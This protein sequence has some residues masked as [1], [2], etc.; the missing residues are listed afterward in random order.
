MTTP[1][2]IKFHRTVVIVSTLTSKNGVYHEKLKPFLGMHGWPIGC[3]KGY[4]V[5]VQFSWFP[6]IIRAVP[7]SLLTITHKSK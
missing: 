2:D 6:N 3:S 7:A 1:Q 4:Q 5:L